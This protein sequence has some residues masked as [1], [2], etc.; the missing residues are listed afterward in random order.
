MGMGIGRGKG[1]AIEATRSAISSPLLDFPIN[2]AKGIMF[3]FVGGKDMTMNEI[4]EAS[5]EI[6]ERIDENANIIF[7]ALIDDAITNGEVS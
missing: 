2:M 7:G 4:D 6:Y 5:E 3:N 1:R